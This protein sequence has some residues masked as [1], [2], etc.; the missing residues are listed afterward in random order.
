MNRRNQR[1]GLVWFVGR[2][3]DAA[4]LVGVTMSLMRTAAVVAAGPE[5]NSRLLT[6]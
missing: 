1:I 5:G 3:V 4:V 6:K 2:M